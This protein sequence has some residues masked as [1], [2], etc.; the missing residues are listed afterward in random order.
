MLDQ[1]IAIQ[2]D[3]DAKRALEILGLTSLLTCEI[4]PNG[5]VV[6]PHEE[7]YLD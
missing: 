6:H 4:T 1:I 5:I 7:V 3:I 2:E